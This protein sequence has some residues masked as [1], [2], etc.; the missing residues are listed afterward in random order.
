MALPNQATVE[1]P[2][3]KLVIV[4]DGGT[5]KTT[6]VKRHLTGEFEKKYEPTIGVEVHPLDFFTNYGK[7]R[8]YCWDT[9]GQEKF[10]GLRD[11][12]YIHGQCA[13]IMFDVT[14]RLTYK[15]VPTWHRDLCRVCENI[16]IVLCG[17][18]VDVKNRQVKAKQV[19]FHRKKNLQYYE[20]S[21]KSNY[22][23][24]KPFLY[25][26]RKLAG[27]TELQ[28]VESPALAPPEVQIDMAV[29]AQHEAE[30]AQAA[31]Q[32]LPDE[33]DDAFE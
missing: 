10:G 23:F 16:P 30:L 3:F 9:A 26:A 12:Y 21:A 27:N 28:F 1:Y 29:Q 31:A 32:P 14:A 4:G 18:K 33:D 8:F 20:I 2:S 15:N 7:I 6:F 5:G 11:G 13:I 22:N 17:N 19:T 24:E 25:L